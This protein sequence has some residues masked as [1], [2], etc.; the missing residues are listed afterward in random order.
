M[1]AYLHDIPFFQ[2]HIVKK[3]GHWQRCTS[4]PGCTVDFDGSTDCCHP[5]GACP[6]CGLSE[7]YTVR[8]GPGGVFTH[9][10]GD[11]EV[12]WVA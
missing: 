3:D 5:G 6:K 8:E 1:S 2:R 9:V 4:A 11:C 7:Y 12:S 10:C